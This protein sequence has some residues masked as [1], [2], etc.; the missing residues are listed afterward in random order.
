MTE[1]LKK[2][3]NNTNEVPDNAEEDPSLYEP[4]WEEEFVE[5]DEIGGLLQ[6]MGKERH[7]G[8]QFRDEIIREIC[9]ILISGNK[10]NAM[11]IGPAGSGKTNI[12]EELAARLKRNDKSIPDKLKGYTVCSISLSDIVSGTGLVGDLERKVRKL[13]DH[14]ESK[15]NKAILFL[16]E[17][18]IL[19]GGETYKKVAQMLKPALSRG[20]FMVIAATTTQE[21]KKIDDDPAFNRRF[22]RIFVD[23]LTK[24]QTEKILIRAVKGME[25]H[26][27]VKIGFNK[28]AARMLVRAA[29]EFCSVGSHRPDNALT[30]MDR[31]IASKVIELQTGGSPGSDTGKII[32]DEKLVKDTAFRLTSG[33]SSIKEFDEKA[34]R[35]ALGSIRGQ[36]DI[37]DDLTKVIKLYDMHLRPH[38]RP[39]TFLFAGP[40]GVG[41]SEAAKI[42]ARE[43]I[44]EKPIILNMAEY[45]TPA[46]V[47][48]I[49]GSPVGYVGSDSNRELPFDALDT[50]PYQVILLDEFEK[51]DRSVQ[52]L[53]M[54]VFDEGVMVTNLGKE[55]DFTKTII[56]ATTNAGCTEKTGSIGFGAGDVSESLS[57]S[58][59]SGYFDTELINRFSH[60]YTFHSIPKTVYAGIIRECL[61]KEVTGL[62]LDRVSSTAAKRIRSVVTDDTVK[63]LCDRSYNAKLGARPVRSAIHEFIDDMVLSYIEDSSGADTV[64]P[65]RR[66]LCR[67]RSCVERERMLK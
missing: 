47:N 12:V 51:C 46:S 6:D 44:G 11:L 57:V 58:D 65:V 7:S 64:K 8:T 21:V 32:L 61:S 55:I 4:V 10:P 27:G 53:F 14:L 35:T 54:S 41:K 22:T 62:D 28:A 48:R 25:K 67:T 37:L 9:A 60:R 38:D 34:F 33:N 3:N 1:E 19:F 49:I 66:K 26:Y 30:L 59:L 40:S 24:D 17:V 45:N 50:N 43:Y 20:K 18:H 15:E 13:I 2:V 42:I 63:L 23:E 16:D 39:L 31:A 56:I 29:D 5:Y 52:R 36:D